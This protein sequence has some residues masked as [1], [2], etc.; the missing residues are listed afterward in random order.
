MRSRMVLALPKSACHWYWRMGSRS[1]ASPWLLPASGRG[2]CPA[3]PVGC[4][5]RLVNGFR[6]CWLHRL[7]PVRSPRNGN[8]HLPGQRIDGVRRASPSGSWAPTRLLLAGCHVVRHIEC[9]TGILVDLQAGAAGRPPTHAAGETLAPGQC[10][11]HS[12]T[13][14]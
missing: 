7:L 10:Q 14:H 6:G 3:N 5:E 11:R 1:G 9:D 13:R 2:S 8:R 4:V 12:L